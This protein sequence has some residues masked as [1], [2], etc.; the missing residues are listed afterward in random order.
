MNFALQ[1]AYASSHFGYGYTE[2]DDLF[3]SQSANV[4]L[5]EAQARIDP[6]VTSWSQ[7]RATF[8]KANRY[9]STDSNIAA[10]NYFS[11]ALLSIDAPRDSREAVRQ[12]ISIFQNGNRGR[13]INPSVTATEYLKA[14]ETA[15][16]F[17]YS[18]IDPT[19]GSGEVSA[20][21][22]VKRAD[23]Q[24]REALANM[25]KPDAGKLAP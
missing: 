24:Y 14:M 10:T 20:R 17:K 18:Q 15:G 5:A 8:A 25:G 7:V 21:P 2:Y 6:D 9:A 13:D 1:D 23:E 16:K 22:R 11:Q 19:G 4:A 12:A 3:A